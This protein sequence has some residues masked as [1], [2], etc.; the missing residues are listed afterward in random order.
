MRLRTCYHGAMSHAKRRPA[1]AV[2]LLLISLLLLLAACSTAPE[3][4]QPSRV[5][6]PYPE[7]SWARQRAERAAPAPLHEPFLRLVDTSRLR[8]GM[9]KQQVLKVF[10]DPERIEISPRDREVWRY[11][12]AE[13]H[14]NGNRLE[15]WFNTPQSAR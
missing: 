12:F 10:P 2:A 3:R 8:V 14:F 15:N 6:H 1:A 4:A 11:E 13:L 5:A 7:A 9:S